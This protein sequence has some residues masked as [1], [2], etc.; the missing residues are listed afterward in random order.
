MGYGVLPPTINHLSQGAGQSP[1]SSTQLQNKRRCK[2]TFFVWLR[3]VY[4]DSFLL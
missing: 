1:V 4:S 2:L 3:R